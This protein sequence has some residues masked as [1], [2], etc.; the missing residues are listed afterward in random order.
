MN[1]REAL[2]DRVR[3][4]RSDDVVNR[5]DVADDVVSTDHRR[6]LDAP[7]GQY[8]FRLSAA[9][10][11]ERP[12]WQ[13]PLGS[14]VQAPDPVPWSMHS[15]QVHEHIVPGSPSWWPGWP[16]TLNCHVVPSVARVISTEAEGN[17]L[18]A[19]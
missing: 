7:E 12:I 8:L 1:A 9:L 10:I 4:D 3:G 17:N 11:A 16:S 18:D 5:E 15:R 14:T 6:D 19:L 13:F 2:G